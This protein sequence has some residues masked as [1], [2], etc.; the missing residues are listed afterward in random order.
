MQNTISQFL[1]K[2][3]LHL[4]RLWAEFLA[5]INNMKIA[6]EKYHKFYQHYL[7]HIKLEDEFLFPRL[8]ELLLFGKNSSITRAASADHRAIIK[9]HYFMEQ[10]FEKNDQDHLVVSS[11]NLDAA[12]KRHRVRENELHYPVSDK[13]IPL[14]EWKKMVKIVYEKI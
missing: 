11:K 3:H 8:S 1:E 9:L 10:A 4:D 5:N 6:A 13:F 2:D 12:L 14:A 7:L